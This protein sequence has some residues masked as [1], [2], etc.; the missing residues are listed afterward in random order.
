MPE[1][2]NNNNNVEVNIS[3]N[4]EEVQKVMAVIDKLKTANIS[5]Y[6]RWYSNSHVRMEIKN[7]F[8]II[9]KDYSEKRDGIALDRSCLIS[10]KQISI[11]NKPGWDYVPY[12]KDGLSSLPHSEFA[13]FCQT[14]RGNKFQV[15]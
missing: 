14:G 13:S 6:F 5:D 2:S 9:P 10:T 4:S 12:L 8:F 15:N 3:E 11:L 7:V 1:I